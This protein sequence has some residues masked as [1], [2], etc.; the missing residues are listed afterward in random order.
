MEMMP[1]LDKNLNEPLFTQLYEYIKGDI[2]IGRLSPGTQLPSIRNLSNHLNISKN[3]VDTAY[4]Q[5]IAEGYI[6]SR[7]RRGLYVIE[8]DQQFLILKHSDPGTFEDYKKTEKTN[9]D[10]KYDFRMGKVDQDSFPTALWRNLNN[11]V[12]FDNDI[13]SYGSQQGEPELRLELAKYLY[14]SRGVSCSSTQIIIGGGIQQLLS[15]LCLIIG[16]KEKKTI[17]IENPGYDGARAIFNHHGFQIKDIEVNESGIS[18]SKLRQSD[19][20]FVYVTP[21]HQFPLGNVMP[22]AARMNLI[23]WANQVNGYIIEDDYD[24]EFRYKG[25]PIPALQGLDTFDRVIY[26]GTFSKS[27]LPSIRLGYMVLPKPLLEIYQR[28]FNMYEQT[29][30]K[31]HQKTLYLFMQRGHWQKHLRKMRSIYQKKNEILCKAIM[32]QMGN[33]VNI[34]GGDS[35][36]HILLEITRVDTEE[37][38]I[39]LAKKVKVKVYPTLKYWVQQN[40]APN[41]LILIGFGGMSA[42]EIISGIEKLTKAW[43]TK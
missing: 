6:E 24:S 7:P 31:I 42:D 5:L 10:Y 4:Q 12:L 25:K 15:L 36:L 16:F 22:I 18:L 3:T 19:A 41:P 37:N 43:F 13:F 35:G 14:Q 9:F 2:E 1:N 29:V 27:L 23:Q 20:R 26:L 30:S 38:L 21:S 34:I 28:E 11:Q 32:K 17:A 33:K 40:Q 8:Y 39:E